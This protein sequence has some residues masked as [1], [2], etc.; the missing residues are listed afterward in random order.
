MASPATLPLDLIVDVIVQVAPQSPAQPTFDQG[1][2]LGPTAVIPA[3]VRLRK[4]TSP[5]AMISDGFSINNPEYIS[6]QLYFGQAEPP[7]IIWI[8]REDLTSIAGAVPHAANEGSGYQINDV[9]T[10]VQLG[11]SGG[12]VLVTAVG[13]GG[14]VTAVQLIPDS[15]AG[16]TGTGYSVANGLLTTGGHGVGAEID[17]TS[18]G[19]TLLGALQA[20]RN[21]S[22]EWWP[23][24]CT[25]AVKADHEAIALFV[26]SATPDTC[27]FYTTADADALSGIAGNVF[28][29]LKALEYSRS[30]GIYSTSQGGAFPNNAYAAAAVMGVAMG[31]N[32]G[33]ANSYFTLKFKT[34]VGITPEPL[35]LTSIGIINGN[36]GNL[37]LSYAAS[38]QFIQEGV[39]ANGQFFD[40]VLNLDMLKSGIQF[41]V[42]NVLVS[43]PSIPQTDAGE[44]Q[45]IHA[46]N[47]ACEDARVRGF[48]A[49]G[50]WKG[51]QIINLFPGTPIPSGYLAQSYPYATQ[52]TADRELRKAMP[53]YVAIIEA[54]AVHFVTV[55]V[56]VQR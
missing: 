20:C 17:I 22:F 25:N 18:V 1:L 13:G 24:M 40:E 15:A 35:S 8:G 11:A 7:R 56:F 49:G 12:R 42:M 26:E 46:V 10:V 38:Y 36:H 14:A 5:A 45:L 55:G 53:I 44:T 47:Q 23:C 19:D 16:T 29:A 31:M 33:L 6:A 32:T 37:Y 50:I 30:W 34:L 28:S 52:N 3:S 2:V 54:G 4:Y 39:M 9:L 51:V 43:N 48:L 41:N 27:Y 21:A